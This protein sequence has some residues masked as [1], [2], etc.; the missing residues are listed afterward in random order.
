MLLIIHI[1]QTPSIYLISW[2]FYVREGLRSWH[3]LLPIGL[4]LFLVLTSVAQAQVVRIMPL[5]DSITY[6]YWGY[7]D[8]RTVDMITGYRQALFLALQKAGHQ[9]EFVGTLSAGGSATPAFDPRHEGHG[10]WRDDQVAANIFAWLTANP[11]EIVLLHIG[12]NGLEPSAKD[13]ER[14][15]DEIDRFSQNTFVILARI[16]NRKTYSAMTTE[17]NNVES[18]AKARIAN[19]DR[20]VLVDMEG[21]LDYS[22][23]MNDNL[24]PN[25]AGY[26]KMANIWLAALL[27]LLPLP[28]PPRLAPMPT[29]NAWIDQQL[30]L[31][32]R[33][34]GSPDPTFSLSNP[35]SGMVIEQK[36]GLLT[37]RAAKEESRT[38]TVQAQNT[39][40]IDRLDLKLKVRAAPLCPESLTAAWPLD[41]EVNPFFE[42]FHR[43]PAGSCAGKCPA[44]VAGRIG[45][46]QAFAQGKGIDLSLGTQAP[47]GSF[48]LSFWLRRAATL[49]SGESLLSGESG[50]AR[51][52][53]ELTDDG[54]PLVRWQAPGL[55]SVQ[56]VGVYPLTDGDW[57]HVL[58]AFDFSAGEIRLYVD[59]E[60]D[61][62]ASELTGS[63]AATTILH[64]GRSGRAGVTD[65]AG[66][67]DEA[68][69]FDDALTLSD[70]EL[71]HA[72]G[73]VGLGVCLYA[74]ELPK[75]TSTP[76]LRGTVGKD[77]FYQVTATG[78]P[79]P[80]FLLVQG[81]TG[82]SLSVESGRLSW[83]PSSAGTFP[84][85]IRA[86]N[87]NGQ[88]EQ[89]FTLDIEP[90]PAPPVFRSTAPNRVVVDEDYRYPVVI[91]G[92]PSPTLTLVSAPSGMTL[93]KGL[94][95]WTP[96]ALGTYS[97][98]L[99]GANASG[100]TEQSFTIL[101]GLP[102][103]IAS[104][105]TQIATTGLSYHY[106]VSVNGYPEPH[107]LLLSAPDD[108]HADGGQ[109]L[110]TPAAP[111]FYSVVFRATNEFND[112]EQSF[113]IQVLQPPR[114]LSVP[115]LTAFIG[116]DYIYELRSEGF[117]PPAV[118]L[119]SPMPPGLTYDEGTQRLHGRPT[120]AGRYPV[121]LRVQNDAG[122]IEQNFDL[123]VRAQRSWH[124]R[125]DDWW[126]KLKK[127]WRKWF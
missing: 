113:M 57:H 77:W 55:A 76:P 39:A 45:A 31:Q 109:I 17:F 65:F 95:S 19:G 66:E 68:A 108:M 43:T 64:L 106:K 100:Q 49:R 84:V 81:P 40:G 50:S 104:I 90:P 7:G 61:G 10:G 126:R 6:G 85:T 14:I 96:S 4:L 114:I 92:Y 20:I 9:V 26:D 37:W 127:R 54:L 1:Q 83:T 87:M 88:V 46:G 53:I 72:R 30:R 107:I 15:L 78:L 48:S 62:T 119:L 51:W 5:G 8:T 123:E 71:I 89:K 91:D 52:F 38:V 122:T 34:T 11:A 120:K 25:Q 28:T 69:L 111:G 42:L 12:T 124:G 59:G 73:A 118:T 29:V 99:R 60:E 22:K 23:D 79:Q 101:V 35:P 94:L 102:P 13:V 98:T 116:K 117:P 3:R 16:I 47:A 110:W 125:L 82:M 21:A 44:P 105:P 27:K 63:P 24:H 67:L 41:E 103:T 86:S 36:T 75:I 56:L 2:R 80:T 32:L 121:H 74:Q 115:M 112:A 58:A 70:A 18:M 93:S 97:V 33:A